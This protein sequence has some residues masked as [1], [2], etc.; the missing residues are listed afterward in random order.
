VALAD[1]TNNKRDGKKK[2]KRKKKKKKKEKEQS[3]R[4]GPGQGEFR[5]QQNTYL[6]HRGTRQK[7]KC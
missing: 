7:K 5:K 3:K 6:Q 1:R 4:E 2:K